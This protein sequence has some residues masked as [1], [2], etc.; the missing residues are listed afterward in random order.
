MNLTIGS[1]KNPGAVL[2]AVAVVAVFGF[3]SLAK[4]PVQLFPDIERPQ[5]SV[6]TGWRSASP[7]A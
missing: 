3:F 4:L 7:G 5:I 1:L 6:W 2:V